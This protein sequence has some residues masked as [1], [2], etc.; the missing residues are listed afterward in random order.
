MRGIR[1]LAGL[2][3]AVVLGALVPRAV[4][5]SPSPS[6]TPGP[7]EQT[8]TTTGFFEHRV[9][10]YQALVRLGRNLR[11]REGTQMLL[12]IAQGSQ[13]GPGDGWFKSGQ[14][15]YDWK[16]LAGR[17]DGDANGHV[18][19]DEFQG[20]AELFER[21]DRNRDGK[22][23]AEDFDWSDK[24]PFAR[25]AGMAGQWVRFLDQNSNGRVSR[26][27]W[28]AFFERLAKQKGYVTPDDLRVAFNPPSAPR[29]KSDGP[30]PLVLMKGLMAGELGSFR[31]GP[32][33][34]QDAPD[35]ALKTQDGKQEIRLSQ[36]R[37]KKPVVLVFGSFT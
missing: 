4:A 25:Q 30:S 32:A 17:F 23:E 24:S 37:G 31:E 28:Q 9:R 34:G 36:F 8:A 29:S 21:L 19:K 20:S 18:A 22:L 2:A 3:L 13:M 26:E 7:R 35:F 27:E 33:V 10:D 16:W 1:C 14:G 11:Q 6:S 12:A 15:M 5:Q